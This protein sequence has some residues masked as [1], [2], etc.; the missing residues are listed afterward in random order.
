MAAGNALALTNNPVVAVQWIG[1]TDLGT[2]KRYL[3]KRDAA[4]EDVARRMIF[5]VLQHR[6]SKTALKL[7]RKKKD[8]PAL[9]DREPAS[10]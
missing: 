1:D 10:L 6:K 8:V 5:P 3:K 9:H 7:Q 4:L 2:A